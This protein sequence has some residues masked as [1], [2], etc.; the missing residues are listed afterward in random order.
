ML[1]RAARSWSTLGVRLRFVGEELPDRLPDVLHFR[2]DLAS[3]ARA[4]ARQFADDAPHVGLG[5]P[6]RAGPRLDVT[7]VVEALAQLAQ[8]R[9][10]SVA[11]V[12]GVL[13]VR[14]VEE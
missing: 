9:R 11:I 2:H 5:E 1:S 3:A 12:G 4:G 8:R 7:H 13:A 6:R 14:R 10:G